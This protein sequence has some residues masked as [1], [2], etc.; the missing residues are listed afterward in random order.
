FDMRGGEQIASLVYPF[1]TFSMYAPIPGASVSHLLIRD[2]Q[3]AAHRITAFRSFDC[4][5]APGGAQCADTHGIQYH[6]DDLMHY[7]QRHRGAGVS[8]AD[9]IPRTWR[10]RSGVAPVQIADC[11][12]AHCKVSR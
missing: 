4:P 1:D 12:I 10:L 7:I 9:L 8:D 11:V 2:A 6:Y 3:G 5:D